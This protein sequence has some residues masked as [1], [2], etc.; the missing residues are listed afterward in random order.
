[1]ASNVLA[2]LNQIRSPRADEFRSSCDGRFELST[3]FKTPD[4]VARL[5]END[6]ADGLK[7]DADKPEIVS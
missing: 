6:A 5:R 2:F 7:L 1:M 4:E 3:V